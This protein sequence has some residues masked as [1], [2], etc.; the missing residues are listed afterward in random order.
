M[1][2]AAGESIEGDKGKIEGKETRT[3]GTRRMAEEMADREGRVR[4]RHKVVAVAE[5]AM[6][7]VGRIMMMSE[8]MRG[9]MGGRRRTRRETKRKR[10]H[11]NKRERR[12]YAGRC[13]Y[14]KDVEVREVTG[15]GKTRMGRYARE[16]EEM[17]GEAAA[18]KRRRGQEG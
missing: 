18:G 6:V 3:K 5:E 10:R 16:A 13:K 8:A 9:S 7:T 1:R 4:R 11:R 12:Q 14:I 17:Q 15:A 2:A